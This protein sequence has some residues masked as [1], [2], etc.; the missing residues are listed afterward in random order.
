MVSVH[1]H[2]ALLLDLL[3][4]RASCGKHVAMERYSPYGSQES[5]EESRDKMYPEKA[6][7]WG[8]RGWLSRFNTRTGVWVLRTHL[9]T[10]MGIAE[11]QQSQCIGDRNR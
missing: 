9:K 7:P 10:Q 6:C 4:V 11:P 3:W 1:G 8:W 2:L 5:E